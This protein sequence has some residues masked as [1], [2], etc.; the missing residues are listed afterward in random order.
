MPDI[1]FTI[2]DAYRCAKP[3]LTAFLHDCGFRS[4]PLDDYAD[5]VLR[6]AHFT[7]LHHNGS[8]CGLC[9]TYMNRPQR[10]MAYITYIALRP[11]CRHIGGVNYCYTA[12]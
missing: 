3:E 4:A 9:I 10:D 5:K 8:L 1:A 11:Q 12:R 7:A 2:T 6:A